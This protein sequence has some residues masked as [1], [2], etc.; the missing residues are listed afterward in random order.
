MKTLRIADLF[1]GAGGTS[2]GALEAA[3]LMNLKPELTAINHWDV[4]IAT[5]TEN[6]ATSR[7]LLTSID[8]VNPGDL[9]KEGELDMLWASPECTHH[10]VARGGKPINDQSRA[11]AW[12]VIR[13]AD[14]L[15]PAIIMVENVPEFITWGGIG[16]NGRP[17]KQKKGKTFTAWVSALESLG[18]R[19]DWRVLCAANYGD[20]TTRKR[21]FVQCVRGKR[22]IV[23]PEPTH[24]AKG[25]ADLFGNRLPWVPARDIIDWN[26]RGTSIYQR[27]RP[28]SPQT[29]RRILKGL[30]K[31]G[32][33]PFIV[34][35]HEGYGEGRVKSVDDPLASVTGKGAEQL[36]EP[37]IIPQN[38]SNGARSVDQPVPTVTTTSRGI[39]LAEPFLVKFGG[40]KKQPA[41]GSVDEPLPTVTA[42]GVQVGVAEPYLVH[43]RGTSDNQI[44]K[45]SARSV[46]APLPAITAGGGHV[47]V[48]EP[49][50][51]QVNHGSGGG[52]GDAGRTRSM[53]DPLP[54]QTTKNGWAACEPFIVSA[55][56]PKCDARLV[57]DPVGTILTR[58]HR[59][60]V[61]PFIVPHF[62][63]REGQ[64]PRSHS[65][66]APLP[67][68]TSHGAGAL[69]EPFLIAIDHQNSDQIRSVDAP[70]STVSTENRHAVIEPYLIKYYGTGEG[71]HSVSRPIDTITAKDR[72]GLAEPILVEIN[73]QTYLVDILLRM[74][75]P[76]ELA[77]GQGFPRSYKFTG[78]KSQQT[79]QIGNAVPRHLARA[80]CLAVLSQNSD[81]TKLLAGRRKKTRARFSPC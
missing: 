3:D 57:S 23:W 58:D 31:F 28:L 68:V 79:K 54:G 76:H 65:I 74:L 25:S 53:D 33:K 29:H 5:H 15:R 48:V 61:E 44:E 18:Y 43:L 26:L 71:A 63:E 19:V 72:F 42:G 69:A 52:R 51:T 50:L 8:N 24:A 75:Q 27:K 70:L 40:E 47:A 32:L 16:T 64:E 66:N 10:S 30:L 9:Y 4:A 62:G 20:P 39:T 67:A 60:L 22:K 35:Q 77:L 17:L 11:T 36:A 49:F 78:N 2:S 81:I 6:H 56:G 13:W 34:P 55:G 21:L 80:L 12:C 1:C 46:D 73:G 41:G 7:H 14:K 37:F 38:S 59:A 45:H